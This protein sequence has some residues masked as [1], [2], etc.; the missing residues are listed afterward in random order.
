MFTPLLLSLSALLSLPFSS[1]YPHSTHDHA[2]SKALPNQWY[3][4]EDHPVYSLF[5]R[6]PSGSGTDGV[7]YAQVGSPTWSA[8]FP[9][10]SPDI[11]AMPQP[12]VDALNAA[13]ANGKIPNIPIPS[14]V[15]S[16][17]T[18]PQG[19]NPNGQEVCSAYYKCRMPDDIWDAPNGTIGIGFDDGPSLVFFFSLSALVC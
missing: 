5:R 9:T 19:V 7:Q 8:P 15:N 4:P 10:A 11:N 12:W 13:V 16:Y 3:H 1:A 18:Y 17:P 14:L 6:Q 2:V